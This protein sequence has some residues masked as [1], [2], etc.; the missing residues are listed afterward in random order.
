MPAGV[1]AAQADNVSGGT[2]AASQAAPGVYEDG[3][4][5]SGPAG[6]TAVAQN[7]AEQKGVEQERQSVL[8][9]LITRLVNNYNELN[10]KY[11]DLS[12]KYE[13][14]MTA[15][16]SQ[17]AAAAQSQPAPAVQS[18][19]APALSQETQQKMQDAASYEEAK[20][21]AARLNPSA[22]ASQDAK[23]K[24]RIQQQ[25][26]DELAQRTSAAPDNTGDSAKSEKSDKNESQYVK[27]K[28]H[29]NGQDLEFLV[30]PMYVDMNFNFARST[31]TLPGMK[32]DDQP[33]PA[34]QQQPSYSAP[35]P[36]PQYIPQ[37]QYQQP[38]IQPIYMPQPYQQQY[39]QQ[40]Q[41]QTSFQIPPVMVSTVQLH[42]VQENAPADQQAKGQSPAEQRKPSA[43]SP[44]A[45]SPDQ[46]SVQDT[47][48]G[49]YRAQK[50][51]YEKK[52]RD[53]L[54]EVQT[55]LRRQPT[56]IAYALQGSIYFSL[57]D[58]NAAVESWKAAL[59]INPN[60]EDVKAALL[61]YG[62]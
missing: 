58:V 47:V 6:N 12:D 55:S 53:S 49:I 52:Y 36:Q 34:Q 11:A 1:F 7:A 32:K 28:L 24:E 44:Q 46:A 59:E 33:A 62:R 17:S 15:A 18:P 10:A 8:M 56:G 51:F 48:E 19:A 39:Q 38:Q 41:Q 35:A 16:K 23:D 29:E 27:L 13:K 54:M 42:F 4:A 57:G 3:K 26:M 21:L 50:L 43:Y 31:Q 22:P 9:N 30:D 2:P 60:M 5:V 14:L 45:G 25:V 61:R 37:Q 20:A 40:P